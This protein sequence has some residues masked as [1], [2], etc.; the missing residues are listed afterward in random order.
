[1]L[2]LN[3]KSPARVAAGKRNRQFRGAL[4]DDG[5]EKLREAAR[6]HQP[7]KFSTGPRTPAGKAR[8]ALNGRARQKGKYS[9]RQKRALTAEAS[10][11]INRMAALRRQLQNAR[12]S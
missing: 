9:V 5:R 10:A 4:T 12:V 11:L 3:V 7:W 1:M 8:V 2:T 6:R